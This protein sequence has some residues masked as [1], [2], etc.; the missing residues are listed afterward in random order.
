MTSVIGPTCL[1]AIVLNSNSTRNIL[2]P[3]YKETG[4]TTD[5]RLQIGRL[6]ATDGNKIQLA[7][8]ARFV[9][10][11]PRHNLSPSGHARHNG[12]PDKGEI[13]NNF[14]TSDIFKRICRLLQCAITEGLERPF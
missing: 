2:Q 10:K 5:R 14:T 9:E 4:S 6:S 3:K 1:C 13:E 7:L 11:S 8:T 12:A